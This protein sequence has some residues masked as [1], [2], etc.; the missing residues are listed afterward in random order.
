MKDKIY[1]VYEVDLAKLKS[2]EK[3]LYKLLKFTKKYLNINKRLSFS[4]NYIKDEKSVYLNKTYRNKDYIGD[5]LSFPIDD[6]YN[7]Y[8]QLKYKEIG[9]IFIAPHEAKR[10]SLKQK[11]SFKTEISWLFVHGLLHILGFDHQVNEEANVMFKLTDDILSKI[12][13]NYSYN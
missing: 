5:V 12:K 1:F 3:V 4:L 10:K 2:Y 7:I 9:D 13:V 8:S 11:N 6:E